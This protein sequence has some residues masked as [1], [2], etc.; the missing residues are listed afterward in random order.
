VVLP[1]SPLHP[2]DRLLMFDAPTLALAQV[3]GV[4]SER[5]LD[6]SLIIPAKSLD[7]PFKSLAL[8]S[9]HPILTSLSPQKKPSPKGP[10]PTVSGASV[11]AVEVLPHHRY[12]RFLGAAAPWEFFFLTH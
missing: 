8:R 12:A 4:A 5:R 10:A 1:L 2:F 3:I 9:G 11:S 6:I 7:L